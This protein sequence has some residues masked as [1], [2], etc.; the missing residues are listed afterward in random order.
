MEKL[1]NLTQF[2]KL[3]NEKTPLVITANSSEG[4]FYKQLDWNCEWNDEALEMCSKELNCELFDFI[5]L[6]DCTIICDE[7]GFNKGLEV[8]DFASYLAHGMIVGDVIVA[9]PN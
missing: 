3:M 1:K 5:N 7:N 2:E 6:D 9:F 8:N 4:A